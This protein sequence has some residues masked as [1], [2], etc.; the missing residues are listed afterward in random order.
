M[1]NSLTKK[2]RELLNKHLIEA[3]NNGYDKLVKEY[4]LLGANVNTQGEY[5]LT[6]LM[7]MI[8]R[9][10]YNTVVFLL[11]KGAFLNAQDSSGD[12]ALHYAAMKNTTKYARLLLKYGADPNIVGIL[13]CTADQTAVLYQHFETALLIYQYKGVKLTDSMKSVFIALWKASRCTNC[14]DR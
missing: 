13:G 5:G 8:S 11:N 3:A 10:K 12:T 7:Y 1:G 9:S 14:K 4:V 2:E 6:P